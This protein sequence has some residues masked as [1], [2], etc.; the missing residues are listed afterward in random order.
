[1]NPIYGFIFLVIIIGVIVLILWQT[2]HIFVEDQVGKICKPVKIGDNEIEHRRNAG[3]RCVVTQCSMG[4]RIEG[5]RCVE[6]VPGEPCTSDNPAI[7]SVLYIYDS[8]GTVCTLD[9]CRIGYEP[10]DGICVQSDENIQGEQCEPVDRTPNSSLYKYN[11]DIECILDT[12][13]PKFRIDGNRCVAIE[14]GEPCEPVDRTPNSSLYKYNQDIECILDTCAPRFRIDGN[15]CLENIPGQECEPVT[16]GTNEAEYRFNNDG[17]CIVS[18]C[19]PKFR[20]DGN[21]CVAIEPG[22][23]CEPVDRTLNS[24]TYKYNQDIECI[25]DTCVQGYNKVGNMC[26]LPNK[27]TGGTVSVVGEY[28]IHTFTGTENLIFTVPEKLTNI[29]I[30][31]VAGGGAGG[32][33][34]GIVPCVDN[35]SAT[36]DVIGNMASWRIGGGGGAGGLIYRNDYTIESGYYTIKVG[37]GG[38]ETTTMSPGANGEDSSIGDLL[39]AK[40]G[41]GG[42]GVIMQMSTGSGSTSTAESGSMNGRQGGSGGG[43][44]SIGTG[45]NGQ[46]GQGY[47]GGARVGWGG[48]DQEAGGGGGAGGA[49]I[50]GLTDG[51][52]GGIGKAYNISG[53]DVTYASGGNYGRRTGDNNP[54]NFGGSKGSNGTDGLGNGGQGS[55][56]TGL[57]PEDEGGGAST[58]GA[59]GSGIVIIRYRTT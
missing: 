53:Q 50:Y 44:A 16:R 33:T 20:I 34:Q 19:E 46:S 27:A 41:G 15:R 21:R 40:G 12:C 35:C 37:K 49:G 4:H 30:L 29:E 14:P 55:G 9:K 24:S 56:H 36:D 5:N 32:K 58:G 52:G 7:D 59:G 38:G 47:K 23:Q 22:E 42:G 39:V 18:K 8:T 13:A 25:L 17:E 6:N 11:Q 43:A 26:F 54:R 10:V 48:S 1:M 31:V 28:T 45:G 2:G 3:G 57:V 51:T